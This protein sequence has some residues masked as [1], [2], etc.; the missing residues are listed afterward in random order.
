[1]SQ[2]H[3]NIIKGIV[4]PIVEHTD[5]FFELSEQYS[6]WT[7]KL[8]E[9][10]YMFR[11]YIHASVFRMAGWYFSL[12]VFAPMVP[13]MDYVSVMQ[14]IEYLT[15]N[16]GPVFGPLIKIGGWLFFF[17]LE[18]TVG[19]LLVFAPSLGVQK[20]LV[21]VLATIITFTPAMLIA[22]TYA[23]TPDKT[24]LLLSK[25]VM[26]LILSVAL[27]TLV[28]LL[29][30]AIWSGALHLLYKYKLKKLH[31]EDPH[32]QMKIL[33]VELQSLF[34]DFDL[35]IVRNANTKDVAS[36]LPNRT[37]YLKEKFQKGN[38]GD[39]YD[40]SDYDTSKSYK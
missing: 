3:K 28:L 16:A 19:W 29:S 38:T 32:K 5:R 34:T 30:K 20:W 23:I 2:K 4:Y 1:M 21:K 40:L 17:V 33:K 6:A 25:T 12:F 9:L 39:E 26:L 27:H 14:F 36:E 22:T 37:R 11:K 15:H 7:T 24:P 8:L 18:V 35:Y 10:E 31:N 13:V